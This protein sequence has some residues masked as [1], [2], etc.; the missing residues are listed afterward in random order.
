NLDCAKLR[1]CTFKLTKCIK[2]EKPDLIFSTINANN[3]VLLLARLL[4]FKKTPVI[5]REANNRTQSGTVSWI[6]QRLTRFLYN[7]I[8]NKVIALSHGVKD[9]LVENFKVKENKVEVIYNPVEINEII[10]FS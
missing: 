2:K 3:I 1:F 10:K 7:V 4:S 9:D 8:A 5:V 6:N